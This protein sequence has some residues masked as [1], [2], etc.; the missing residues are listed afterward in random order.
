[1]TAI[2]ISKAFDK[3]NRTHLWAKLINMGVD[4]ATIRA[5]IS[6]YNESWMLILKDGELGGCFRTTV[7]VRQGGVI[8]PKLFSI[9]L[10][11]LVS[12]IEALNCGTDIGDMKV[13]VLLYADDIVLLS[14]TKADMQRLL[15]EIYEFGAR[16]DLVF[17][18]EK[19]NFMVINKSVS[20]QEK[21]AD[22][23]HGDISL[24]GSVIKQVSKIRFLGYIITEN[25]KMTEHM[26]KRKSTTI[27]LIATLRSQSLLSEEMTVD[28]KIRLFKAFI[29]P[30]LTFG[31]ENVRL[32]ENFIK[33]VRKLEGNV[34]KSMVGIPK[35]CHTTNLLLAMGISEPE[36]YMKKLK[37]GFFKRLITNEY[38]HL[39]L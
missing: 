2:D 30:T 19:T 32:D 24:N 36:V 5:L 23:F 13:D 31:V 15:D 26:S 20:K 35:Q 12:K 29:R 9:Y 21:D 14:R 37:L 16:N 34:L 25:G 39:I 22:Y 11:S 4:S 6:Y 33:D 10:D 18:A 7:G 28:A 8:S 38:T 3:V 1:M 17:N 27:S